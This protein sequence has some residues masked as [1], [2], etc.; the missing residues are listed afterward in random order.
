MQDDRHP[1]KWSGA[2]NGIAW[3]SQ[4]QQI[5]A[6]SSPM[7]V[8]WQCYEQCFTAATAATSKDKPKGQPPFLGP[9]PYFDMT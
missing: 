7:V 8:T 6:A 2:A 3:D 5:R 1:I 4:Q 9:N